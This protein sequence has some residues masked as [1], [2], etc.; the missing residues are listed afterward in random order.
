[1]TLVA[2]G[3]RGVPRVMGMGIVEEKKGRKGGRVERKKGGQ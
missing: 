3:E 1:M 2:E